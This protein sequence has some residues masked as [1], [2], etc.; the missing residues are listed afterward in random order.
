[1]IFKLLGADELITIPGSHHVFRVSFVA[2]SGFGC[3]GHWILGKEKSMA[4]KTNQHM[5]T[6]FGMSRKN[7]D[8]YKKLGRSI[9]RLVDK[10]IRKKL[11]NSNCSCVLKCLFKW[12]TEA[13]GCQVYTSQ[14]TTKPVDQARIHFCWR[15]R[16][17][18]VCLVVFWAQISRK[19]M[20]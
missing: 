11:Q 6:C 2:P 16:W 15:W 7:T 9:E 8:R 4:K 3:T 13:P 12:P 14:V 10:F 18:W 20:K 1:M 19:S 17:K 5:A